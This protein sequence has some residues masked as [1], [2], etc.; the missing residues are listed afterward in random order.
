MFSF[1]RPR[2]QAF[3]VFDLGG[4]SINA[5][6]K[7]RRIAQACD[8]DKDLLA[9][10]WKD[11]FPRA[12]QLLPQHSAAVS[13]SMRRNENKDAWREA[14]SRLGE[15]RSTAIAHPTDTLRLALVH[16]LAL[17][18]STSGV[19]Q[20]FS[21]AAWAYGARRTGAHASTEEACVKAHLDLPNHDVQK[22]LKLCRV[23]WASCFGSARDRLKPRVDK[24]LKRPRPVEAESDGCHAST[25]AAFISKRR[26]AVSRAAELFQEGLGAGEEDLSNAAWSAAHDKELK[27]S[28]GKRRSRLVQAFAEN[29]LLEEERDESLREAAQVC[30]R[31]ML[32]NE[33]QRQRARARLRRQEQG[34]LPAEVLRQLRG[35]SCFLAVSATM[36]LTAA[37]QRHGLRQTATALTAD[38]L[39]T[40]A[41]GSLQADAR[42][43]L[44]GALRGV[45]E[46]SP[47]LLE[48]QGGAALKLRPAA[49]DKRVLLVSNECA[50]ASRRFW[51]FLRSALPDGHKWSLHKTRVE[52]L[53]AEQAKHRAGV[54]YA[55]VTPAQTKSQAGQ[56]G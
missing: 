39:V 34:A 15:H 40:R 10:Q 52:S 20:S 11:V 29:T 32:K 30:R 51:S 50:V 13:K 44:A 36:A 7:L 6:E 41:P 45:L 25:E 37:L 3:E 17:G 49:F 48:G 9:A 46:V 26:K 42:V 18:G 12:Q 56:H 27:F 19:E 4:G 31:K 8:V 33:A 24:G 43:R 5:E 22:L 38:V 23:V 55:V 47:C 53:R 1:G 16:Y 35:K 54:A 2:L 21:K 28:E 14:L